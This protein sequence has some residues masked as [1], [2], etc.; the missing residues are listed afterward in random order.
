MRKPTAATMTAAPMRNFVPAF[1]GSLRE[2]RTNLDNSRTIGSRKRASLGAGRGGGK[3]ALPHVVH[4]RLV[5]GVLGPCRAELRVVMAQEVGVRGLLGGRVVP[6][7]ADGRLDDIPE[8]VPGI[9]R[10]DAVTQCLGAGDVD[11]VE[12]E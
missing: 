6:P 11:G 1:I 10:Q 3:G 4:D 8:E 9:E 7:A 12:T 5:G 2:S